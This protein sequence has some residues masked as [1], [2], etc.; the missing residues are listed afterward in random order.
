MTVVGCDRTPP[1]DASCVHRFVEVAALDACIPT[2]HHVAL[3]LPLTSDTKGLMSKE[4]IRLMRQGA[5]L[6]NAG[7]GGL[8]DQ[9][10]LIEALNDGALG[11]AGLDAT[12]QEPIPNDDPLW[13][14]PNVILT[15]HSGG[16][17]PYNSRRA[18]DL[19]S[20][21]LHRFMNGYPLLNLVDPLRGY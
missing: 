21:N 10:S 9:T 18:T 12:E 1:E 7:R 15:Q 17:S 11:G 4:R 16:A 8:V 13:S 2:A 20:E 3:C 6:Y 5:Y 19:F 14:A